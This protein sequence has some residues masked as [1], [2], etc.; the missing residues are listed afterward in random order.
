MNES[1]LCSCGDIQTTK[2]IVETCPLTKFDGGLRG[3]CIQ[4][5]RE[6]AI[7]WMANLNIRL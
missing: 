6:N 5:G 7:E 3:T 1:P 4:E 2:H